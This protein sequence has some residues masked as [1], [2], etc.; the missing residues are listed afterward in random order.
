MF[1]FNQ[2][3][4][5]Y[6]RIGVETGVTAANPHKLIVMLYE[7]AIVACQSALQHMQ[8]NDVV[9][10]GVLLSKAI[11]II[12]SGLRLSLDKKAGGDIAESLDALYTY[13]SNLLYMANMKNQPESIREVIRLLTELKAAWEAIATVQANTSAS[14][15]LA[16]KTSAANLYANFD[17]A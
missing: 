3:V 11:M 1:G 16:S 14:E 13:M 10:K 9:N 17:R 12:E 2:G 15:G 8:N 5:A 4:H 7:G 6:N